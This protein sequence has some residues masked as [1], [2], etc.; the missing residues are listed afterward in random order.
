ML[1]DDVGFLYAVETEENIIILAEKKDVGRIIGKGGEGLKN[2]S[3]STGARIKVVGEGSLEELA[4]ELTAP[5]KVT[6]I[7]EVYGDEKK[8]RVC[9]DGKA[10]LRIN[11]GVLE[12][13][14][15]KMSGVKV[16]LE[17]K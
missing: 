7:K 5:A 14:L 12:K 11:S 15:S 6:A 10:D 17:T 1:F 2:L 3:E 13:L 16:E 8:Y 9:V 4:H